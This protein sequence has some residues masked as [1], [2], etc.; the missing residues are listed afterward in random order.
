M[1]TTE[2]H[3]VTVVTTTRVLMTLNMQSTYI[4]KLDGR[5]S[6]MV[7]MSLKVEDGWVRY[8]YLHGD[9]AHLF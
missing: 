1:R 9:Y 7:L 3:G 2:N 6:S 8:Q 4:W 5:P